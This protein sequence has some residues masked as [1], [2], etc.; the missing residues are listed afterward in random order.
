MARI[1]K[2]FPDD[3]RFPI[4]VILDKKSHFDDEGTTHN[5]ESASVVYGKCEDCSVWVGTCWRSILVATWFSSYNT[6]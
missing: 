1:K 6:V 5:K 2:G 4:I 3:Q